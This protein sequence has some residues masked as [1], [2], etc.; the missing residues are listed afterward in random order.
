M[1]RNYA[2]LKFGYDIGSR[3][4]A[5]PFPEKT[6][7]AIGSHSKADNSKKPWTGILLGPIGVVAPRTLYLDCQILKLTREHSPTGEGEISVGTAGLQF[8]G[9]GF[10]YYIRTNSNIFHLWQNPNSRNGDQMYSV[11]CSNQLV[12][13]HLTQSQLYW[14]PRGFCTCLVTSPQQRPTFKVPMNRRRCFKWPPTTSDLQFQPETTE[15]SSRSRRSLDKEKQ[16]PRK[17]VKKV[18][19]NNGDDDDGD[20]EDKI[21]S[22]G[23]HSAKSTNLAGKIGSTGSATIAGLL[24]CLPVTGLTGLSASSMSKSMLSFDRLTPRG[25]EASCRKRLG[26]FCKTFFCKLQPNG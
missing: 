24:S 1:Q 8:D 22:D 5:H 23:S 3:I 15:S 4:K 17:L 20:A 21:Q 19:H 18:D 7:L 14:L 25:G 2:T 6:L 9:F 10:H 12:Y 13:Y 26:Q 11:S 16:V